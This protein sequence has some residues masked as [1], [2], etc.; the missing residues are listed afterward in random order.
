MPAWLNQGDKTACQRSKNP[1]LN[2]AVMVSLESGRRQG[3]L[4]ALTWDRVDFAE[5]CSGWKSRSPA[6]G[7]RYHASRGP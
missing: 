2:P 5:A 1:E 3:E 4:L 7:A 6:D